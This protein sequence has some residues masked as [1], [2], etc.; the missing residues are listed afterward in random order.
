MLMRLD[1]LDNVAVCLEDCTAGAV[2]I[3]GD[4]SVQC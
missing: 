2:S 1:S 3:C 4:I